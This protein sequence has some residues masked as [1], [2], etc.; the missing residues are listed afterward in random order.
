[1]SANKL[2]GSPG[3]PGPAWPRPRVRGLAPGTGAG[4]ASTSKPRAVEGVDDDADGGGQVAVA[5]TGARVWIATAPLRAARCAT[6]VELPRVSCTAPVGGRTW[7]LG[8]QS[9]GAV[10]SVR[11]VRVTGAGLGN[12]RAVP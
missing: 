6:H 3:P 2:S 11:V 10:Q 4:A 9:R 5:R 8:W 1:M 7:R 12:G